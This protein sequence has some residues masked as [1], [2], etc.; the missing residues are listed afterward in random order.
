MYDAGTAEGWKSLVAEAARPHL[1]AAPIDGPVELTIRF[2]MPRPKR[3]C[4]KRDVSGP[5]PCPSKPDAD[6]LA[7]AVMDALS[8]CGMWVDDSQVFRLSVSK[9]YHGKTARAGAMVILQ[10]AVPSS[11]A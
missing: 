7:K 5:V 4:R 6:N 2:D 9:V 1:P 11:G 3:L 10:A 8:Q